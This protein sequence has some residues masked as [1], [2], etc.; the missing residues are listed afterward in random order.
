[1]SLYTRE[2]IFKIL[3]LLCSL[4]PHSSNLYCSPLSWLS[5]FSSLI[6]FF[7]RSTSWAYSDHHQTFQFSL[8]AARTFTLLRSS[9]L[10]SVKRL[11]HFIQCFSSLL[12]IGYLSSNQWLPL[13]P[14]MAQSPSALFAL[15]PPNLFHSLK[16]SLLLSMSLIDSNF[17]SSPRSAFE[18]LLFTGC[19]S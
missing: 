7:P 4:E 8:V 14:K 17:N 6:L 12:S 1:M 18:L 5:F 13:S 3:N 19:R 15:V 11:H 16:E 2:L 9:H 10:T